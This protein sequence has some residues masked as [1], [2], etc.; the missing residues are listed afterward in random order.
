MQKDE[1]NINPLRSGVTVIIPCYNYAHFLGATLDSVLAQTYTNLEI[2]VID[3]GS[4]DNTAEVASKYEGRYYEMR[5]DLDFP[6]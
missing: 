3:D 5:K 2:I 6:V 4:P 1:S